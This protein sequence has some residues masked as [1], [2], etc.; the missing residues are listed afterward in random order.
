MKSYH[1][2]E[3]GTL[4]RIKSRREKRFASFAKQDLFVTFQ[5]ARFGILPGNQRYVAHS[6]QWIKYKI[7]DVISRQGEEAT[8]VYFLRK[9]ICKVTV[10]LDLGD[11]KVESVK[12][13]E[14]EP[15]DYFCQ[16]GA[17]EAGAKAN[18]TITAGYRVGSVY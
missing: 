10:E 11:R 4:L 17:L 9:G 15:F 1:E 16:E 8:H 12:V 14:Y 5:L 2:K 7:G 13:G 18:F 6:L 3:V